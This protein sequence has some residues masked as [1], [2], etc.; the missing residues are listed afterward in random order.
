VDPGIASFSIAETGAPAGYKKGATQPA[1]TSTIGS[2]AGRTTADDPDAVFE[3]I[4]LSTIEVLFSSQAAGA[5]D[6]GATVADIDCVD[7]DGNPVSPDAGSD[8]DVDETYS[9]LE[10]NDGIETYTCTIF[11]DP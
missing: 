4:P 5:N 7:G 3:N 8:E 9:D 1:V 6:T 2:C 10:P 11:V